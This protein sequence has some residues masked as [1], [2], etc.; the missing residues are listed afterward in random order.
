MAIIS[1]TITE[2]SNQIISGI[3]VSVSAETNVP[4]SIFY[5]IDGSDPTTF[6]SIYISPII[7]SSSSQSITLKI[8]ATNGSDNSAII[9]K[10][11]TTN[12][13]NDARLPH[14]TVSSLNNS[15]TINSLFPYGTNSPNPSFQYLSPANAGTTVYN[16]LIPSGSNGFDG[17][18]YQAGFTNKPINDYPIVYSTTDNKNEVYP[19]VGDLP[20]T[21]TVI[22]KQGPTEYTQEQ[23]KTTAKLFNPK[24]LVIF[25]DVASEDPTDPV[26]INRAD[27]SLQNPELVRDGA[28]LYNGAFDGP[29][30]TGS[31]VN[32]YFNPRTNTMT[33]YYYD[34]SVSRWIISTTPF[35][36]STVKVDSLANMAFSRS[37][38]GGGGS[39]VYKWIPFMSRRLI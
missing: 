24:A 3:P 36:P 34:N 28:L 19:G 12:L 31:F 21:T 2:A 37:G 26:H 10:I 33:Y 5:T 13:I 27:F 35:D 7:L 20:A 18:G 29:C 9:E 38:P 32:S 17:D 30:T 4:A 22:G 6:S 11:Y 23:S 25:Q 15:S 16:P 1:L 8:F 39:H 14:A